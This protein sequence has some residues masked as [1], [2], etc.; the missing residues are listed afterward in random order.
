MLSRHCSSNYGNLL[1]KNRW[2]IHMIDFNSY[3]IN[4]H[5]ENSY[6]MNSYDIMRSYIWW[7][8][9]FLQW[10]ESPCQAVSHHFTFTM[11]KI[12]L[13]LTHSSVNGPSEKLTGLNIGLHH[14]VYTL[15]KEHWCHTLHGLTLQCHR[16]CTFI[17]CANYYCD[18]S[19]SCTCILEPLTDQSG[20]T[21]YFIDRQ[22]PKAFVKC[23]CLWLQKHSLSWP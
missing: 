3:E 21:T 19:L 16:M 8:W 4:S 20:L 17:G 15:E 18:V 23:M 1:S 5:D 14:E 9:C 13:P 10:L 6:D 11:Q 22:N 2:I 7:C 12:A